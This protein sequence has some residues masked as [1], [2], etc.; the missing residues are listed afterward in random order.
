M[1]IVGGELSGFT[2]DLLLLGRVPRRLGG[3]VLD[4]EV[5]DL[6]TEQVGA[7]VAATVAEGVLH[8][9]LGGGGRCFAC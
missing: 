5:A 3:C 4:H 6:E 9:G 1:L 7:C 8:E 2:Y